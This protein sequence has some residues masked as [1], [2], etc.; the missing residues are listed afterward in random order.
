MI[1]SSSRAT[2]SLKSFR[3]F[4][5]KLRPNN[6]TIIPPNYIHLGQF[7]SSIPSHSTSSFSLKTRNFSNSSRRYTEQGE[8]P[9]STLSPEE[10]EKV[11]E[12]DM[13]TLHEN[14]EIYVEE[15]GANDWE[16]EYSSGVMTLSLP[17]NGTYVINKQPPN[18]QIWMSS[19]FSGPSRFDYKTG[20]GWVHHRNDEVKFKELVESELK[21]LLEKS[22]GDVEGWQGTGL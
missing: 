15:F 9:A 10:Y 7:R 18:L 5:Q 8:K 20:K 2:Q 1:P 21:R 14:L 12:R 6:N 3:L 13:D 22:G 17:P 19:P 11:S 4:T 16:V